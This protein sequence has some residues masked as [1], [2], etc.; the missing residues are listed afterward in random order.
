M[1]RSRSVMYFLF[2]EYGLL[3]TCRCSSF[4]YFLS[5][6]I[7]L[8]IIFWLAANLK[9]LVVKGKMTQAKADN[10]FSLLKGVLDYSEFKDV[11]MVIEVIF[12]SHYQSDQMLLKLNQHFLILLF[13][14]MYFNQ[15]TF[16][17]KMLVISC[18]KFPKCLIRQLFVAFNALREKDTPPNKY[19]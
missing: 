6:L 1:L 10:A 16:M 19:S 7:I 18:F 15:N 9:G 17:F 11:D 14:F 4:P 3:A 13:F 12:F 5:W 2:Q 8:F